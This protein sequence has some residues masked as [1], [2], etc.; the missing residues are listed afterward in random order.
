MLLV[1]GSRTEIVNFLTCKEEAPGTITG[2]LSD[3]ILLNFQREVLSQFHPMKQF[4]SSLL[5]V[6]Q[7]DG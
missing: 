6:Y 3:H 2:V 5:W 4:N 1:S 7:G